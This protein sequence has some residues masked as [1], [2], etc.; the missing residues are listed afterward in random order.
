MNRKIT[1]RTPGW[2]HAQARAC[3]HFLVA[4]L[5]V[6]LCAAASPSFSQT[7]LKSGGELEAA[8][9]AHD[10]G[11]YERAFDLI[12]PL[13]DIG[14]ATAR[15]LLARLHLRREFAGYDVY[16]AF[17]LIQL[18]A[19]QGLP[20]AQHDLAQM[21]RTGIGVE[22]DALASFSWHLRAARQRFSRSE[23][24]IA[25]MYAAGEGVGRDDAQ[26]A[27]W[28]NRAGRSETQ[29]QVSNATVKPAANA[30]VK[31]PIKPQAL[32]P[33]ATKPQ[34]I[35]KQSARASREP[36]QRRAD[37]SGQKA[38]FR[39]QLGAFRSAEIAARIRNEIL[40]ALPADASTRF[41]VKINTSDKGDGN[42]KLHRIV[43]GPVNDLGTAQFI[44]SQV[45]ARMPKQG[46]FPLRLR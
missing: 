13:A 15:H 42:G 11:D 17:R 29:P 41:P 25:A 21:H 3:H 27:K 32:E 22:Q 44:C 43:A 5:A 18:A 4:V 37:P 30:A 31:R 45:K 33:Q 26:A 9:R 10:N 20:I 28:A 40:K 34:P 46:C 39:I 6:V 2:I 23:R 1:P 24:A 8:V 38:R 16:E 12:A 7:T 36:Q 19:N 14:I 35:V